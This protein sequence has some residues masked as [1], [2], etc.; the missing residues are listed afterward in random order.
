MQFLCLQGCT[1]I[2]PWVPTEEELYVSITQSPAV[3]RESGEQGVPQNKVQL[4]TLQSLLFFSLLHVKGVLLDWCNFNKD[5][6]LPPSQS[7]KKNKAGEEQGAVMETR[8]DLSLGKLESME[9]T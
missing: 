1:A 9:R 6:N 5:R 3:Q 7:R 2:Q 8:T 4:L